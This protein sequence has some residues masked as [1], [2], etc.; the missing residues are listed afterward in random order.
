MA[1]PS[2]PPVLLSEFSSYSPPVFGGPALGG[3]AATA[4][5]QPLRARRTA[6][7]HSQSRGGRHK[8]PRPEPSRG[9]R[10]TPRDHKAEV[11][12]TDENAH[13]GR[14]LKVESDGRRADHIRRTRRGGMGVWSSARTTRGSTSD[15]AL[16]LPPRGTSEAKPHVL[17]SLRK[18]EP[19][20]RLGI[21]TMPLLMK[22][23]V[24]VL[25]PYIAM[26]LLEA[27]RCRRIPSGA[28]PLEPS[29]ESDRESPSAHA[30]HR[31]GIIHSTGT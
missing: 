17:A 6:G 26:E 19:P 23:G 31:Q 30:R 13:V 22:P 3:P 29:F 9:T 7:F 4:R 8:P 1:A 2:P 15:V 28:L 16:K 27:A 21:P 11:S 24:R 5:P 25:L 10:T 12:V 18:R 20:S 14:A